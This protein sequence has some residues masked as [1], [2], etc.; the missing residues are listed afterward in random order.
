MPVSWFA[1][2]LICP[3][4]LASLALASSMGCVRRTIFITSE[5]EG[6]LVYLNDTE[7]GRTPVEVDFL[8]YGDYDVRLVHPDREPLVTMGKARAPWWDTI[9]LDLIAEAAPGEPHA[10]IHW[11]Y[12]LPPK[13]DDP[14]ALL[15]RARALR[16]RVGPE[17]GEA[18]STSQN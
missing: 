9:G 18:S 5:P 17:S 6:A 8:Y 2:R 1:L 13:S 11:H 7:V 10:R 16:E 12:E 3:A 4:M 15:E 14:A